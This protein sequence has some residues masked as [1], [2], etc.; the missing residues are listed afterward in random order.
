[1]TEREKLFRQLNKLPVWQ[2]VFPTENDFLN[3]MVDFILK[4]RKERSKNYQC[5]CGLGL[6]CKIHKCKDAD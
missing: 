5:C 3:D 4:D 6:V 1:M 2:K